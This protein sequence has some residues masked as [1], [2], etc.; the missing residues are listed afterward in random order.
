MSNEA[1]PVDP[2]QAILDRLTKLEEENKALK[3]KAE[4][5]EA[6]PAHLATNA[7]NG[8]QYRASVARSVTI[9]TRPVVEN[10]EQY[11]NVISLGDVSQRSGARE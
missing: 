1:A 2:M 5:A 10:P 7:G 4:A 11:E 3:A 6:T 8:T 9:P